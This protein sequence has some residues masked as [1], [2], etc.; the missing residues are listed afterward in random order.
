M[1]AR[2]RYEVRVS[3]VLLDNVLLLCCIVGTIRVS[4]TV[5]VFEECKREGK[6]KKED[7]KLK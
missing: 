3:I 7:I 2:E 6:G 4:K 1:R 5:C